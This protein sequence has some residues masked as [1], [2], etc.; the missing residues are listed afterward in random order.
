M[1]EALV[2]SR[3]GVGLGEAADVRDLIPE[4]RERRILAAVGVHA[5]GPA[6]RRAGRDRPVDEPL[7]D[8]GARL[9]DSREEVLAEQCGIDPL[10]QP[11]RD[12]SAERDERRALLAEPAH[13]FPVPAG[14]E[15]QRARIGVAQPRALDV[16]IEHA[17]IDELRPACIRRFGER[18]RERLLARLGPD[19]D[20][21]A[22]LYVGPQRDDELRQITDE[23]CGV[24]AHDQESVGRTSPSPGG[25]NSSATRPRLPISA[26]TRSRSRS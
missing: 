12:R 13:T 23:L 9:P 10:H 21:L 2:P 1:V 25:S 11:R 7:L 4:R 20:D 18:T 15:C 19:R 24:R 8:Q 16:L 14:N 3:Q 17:H 22:G 5:R 26:G 6:R